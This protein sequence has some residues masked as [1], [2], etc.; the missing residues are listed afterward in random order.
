M[1]QELNRLVPARFLSTVP[2]KR[3]QQFPRYLKA[4][5]IRAER[6]ATN[7]VK[8]QAKARQIVPYQQRLVSLQNRK[9]L[10]AE[11]ASAREEFRWMIEEL[12]V[13]L[14][15]QELGTAVPVSPKRLDRFLEEH[16]LDR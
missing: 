1:V 15:A 14:Y 10:S 3:L 2:W 12:K 16:R 11:Q 9:D 13:S 6:W 4:L 7:P 8:D 5:Q